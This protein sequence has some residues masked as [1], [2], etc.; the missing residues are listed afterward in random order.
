[1]T[2]LMPLLATWKLI[3]FMLMCLFTSQVQINE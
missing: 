3:Y 1:M 2:N